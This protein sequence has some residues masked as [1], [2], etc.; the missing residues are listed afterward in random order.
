MF[1]GG[2]VSPTGVHG[3]LGAA[4]M[5]HGCPDQGPQTGREREPLTRHMDLELAGD[6]QL[7]WLRDADSPRTRSG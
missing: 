4:P 6:P 3:V 7:H 2:S 1:F 5:I